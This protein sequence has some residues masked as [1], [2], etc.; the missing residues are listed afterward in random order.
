[1]QTEPK[2]AFTLI[3]LLVVIAIIAILASLLLPALN[4]AK[5]KGR[6]ATCSSQIKQLA[7]GMLLYTDDYEE[8]MCPSYI[9]G[10]PWA[11]WAAR[12]TSY[13]NNR[14]VYKCPSATDMTEFLSY[15]VNYQ[16]L[17]VNW[18]G[19]PS[20]NSQPGCYQFGGCPMAKI[21]KPSETILNGDSGTHWITT[22]G[23]ASQQM[24]YVINWTAPGLPPP[25][26]NYCVYIRHISQ[27]N[28]G[29]CDGH[30]EAQNLGFVTTEK[31]F[32]VTK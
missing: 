5:E 32:K 13:V 7:L 29:F 23:A 21:T 10:E 27:A 3:E 20:P 6:Q 9:W 1:M 8:R 12:I 14:E 19:H 15:G 24:A 4:Q 11:Y 16:Y 28:I 17:T 26:S 31:N 22:T 30:V 2:R 25:D 18:P